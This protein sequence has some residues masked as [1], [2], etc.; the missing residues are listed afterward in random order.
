MNVYGA[1][2]ADPIARLELAA[3]LRRGIERGELELHH[4]P[5]YRLAD[6]GMMGVESL[7]RWRDPR[8]AAASCPRASSSPSPSARA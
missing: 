4:Q 3:R 5:I 7:V 2:T 6:R 8:A 1:G